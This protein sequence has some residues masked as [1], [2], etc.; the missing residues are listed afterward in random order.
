ME[1]LE[2][3]GNLIEPGQEEIIRMNVG[4]LPSDTRIQIRAHVYRSENPGPV[5]L[6]MG[7]VHGD[8]INGVEI[9]RRLIAHGTIRQITRGTII[10]IPLLNIYGFINFSREVPDGKDVNRSFP[11]RSRG[12]LASRVAN[13]ITKKIL[14][15]VNLGVDFHTGGSNNYNYPQVRYSKGDE[16][17]RKL[18]E[19]FASPYLVASRPIR[20]SFRRVSLDAG[21]PILTYEGGE[22]TR[23]DGFSIEKGIEGMKRV[24][25]AQDMLDLHL[26]PVKSIHFERST[27]IRA[28]RAG[29]FRWT[30]RSGHAVSKGEPIGVIN[31]P[32]GMDEIPVIAKKEG[33]IIGHNNA[34]VVNT[35]D[36]LFHI[37]YN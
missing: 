10:A 15:V 37:G 28:A 9:V 34:P 22:N 1:P 17:S 13:A 24:L 23:F 35:G 25:I 29:L 11:G 6:A 31:D 32:Y 20:K 33:Y 21:I 27:W 26:P 14:P 36:A 3:G 5:V 12:S 7:G 8:E 2:I 18:A 30:K 19:S 4:R 16:L